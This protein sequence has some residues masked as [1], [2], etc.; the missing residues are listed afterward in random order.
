MRRCFSTGARSSRVSTATTP[1]ISR[2]A[3]IEAADQGV[4][5]RTAHERRGQRAG[6]GNII[7]KTAFAGRSA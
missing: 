5:M 4:R 1:G 2:A 7:D 3:G 6:R